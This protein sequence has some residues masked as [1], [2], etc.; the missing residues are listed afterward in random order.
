MSRIP[1]SQHREEDEAALRERAW[2]RLAEERIQEAMA[3]GAFDNLPG[4]GKPLDLREN[5]FTPQE[6]RLAYKLLKDANF[7]PDWIELDRDVRAAREEL[8]AFQERHLDWLRRQ[9]L[10]GDGRA[11]AAVLDWHRRMRAQLARRLEELNR[12]I[13]HLNLIVPQLELQRPRVDAAGIMRRF[14]ERCA[15]AYPPLAQTEGEPDERNHRP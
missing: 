2:R 1:P 15:A 5:P 7:A 10:P 13:D 12:K 8:N 9:P 11:P 4:K 3:Q 6:L 14:D